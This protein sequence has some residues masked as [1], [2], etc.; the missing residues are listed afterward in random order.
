MLFIYRFLKGG[1]VRTVSFV[2]FPHGPPF[3]D[4]GQ[5]ACKALIEVIT[6]EIMRVPYEGPYA[7]FD[8]LLAAATDLVVASAPKYCASIVFTSLDNLPLGVIQNRRLLCKQ[9]PEMQKM[10]WA[11]F[12]EAERHPF[13]Q[14][15]A[16]SLGTLDAD[17]DAAPI[18]T[19]DG[20]TY[21]VLTPKTDPALARQRAR[22]FLPTGFA[23]ATGEQQ[24]LTREE[25][26]PPQRRQ[27]GTMQA[28]RSPS[29][30]SIPISIKK[31]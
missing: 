10:L 12:V 19:V 3:T 28:V 2:L 18:W 9:L 4:D 14:Q 15:G 27:S 16:E 30:A 21:L 26:E 6:G 11:T 24:R 8:N 22:L 1:A 20:Q 23:K 25:L 29:S 5:T 31:P 13:F 7:D 17:L